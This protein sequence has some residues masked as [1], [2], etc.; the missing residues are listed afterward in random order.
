LIARALAAENSDE[1][2]AAKILGLT[3]AALVKRRK[4]L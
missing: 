3:K 2:K 1:A 4:E